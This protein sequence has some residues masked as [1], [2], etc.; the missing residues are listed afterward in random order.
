MDRRL[1]P[2]MLL[3]L[4]AMTA[5]PDVC[6][7]A[8]SSRMYHL[9][10]GAD[11]P[12]LTTYAAAIERSEFTLDKG[13]HFA[14]VESADGADFTNAQGGDLCLAFRRGGKTVY[15]MKD[16]AARP[17]IAVSYPDIMSYAF[18]PFSDISVSATFFV[19]SS[20]H[21]ILS[22][23]ITNRGD[24]AVLLEVRPFL[25]S[26]KRF[27]KEVEVRAD[28]RSITCT[29]QESPD[30][31][32]LDHG[33]PYVA[34]VRDL[35]VLSEVADRS[36]CSQ[37]SL[38][39]EDEFSSTFDRRLNPEDSVRNVAFSKIVDLKPREVHR[40]TVVRSVSRMDVDPALLVDTANRL[41]SLS[42]APFLAGNEKLFGAIPPLKETDPDLQ[43]IDAS[44]FALM[45][46]AMLPPEGRCRSN[47]YVFSREPQWGW[48][49]GGQ[50]FHES[51]TML[52]YALLEPVRAMNSQ[53][54]FIDR[55]KADGYINY[56][57]GPYLDEDIPNN[58][59]LTTSAP[60]Y[61]WQN[62]EVFNVTHD[63]KFLE[64]TYG[65]ASRFYRYYVENRD[66]DGDGLCEWGGNAVLESV[67]DGLVAV[68]DQ[69]G[70]PSEFE[71]VDLNCMLVVEARSLSTMARELGKAADADAWD[72]DA[73]RRTT[74]INRE[75]WDPGTGFYY[76][77]DKKHHSFSHQTKNDLKRQEIIG[78][79]PLWAGIARTDQAATLVAALTDTLKFWRKYGVPSLA[80]DDRYYNPRGYWNGPVWIPWNYLIVRGL[81]RYGYV[82]EA[83]E[84][85]DRIIAAVS[86]GLK[87]GHVF[88]E[89]YSPDEPWGGYHNTYLWDGLISRM[90]RD[91]ETAEIEGG[92]RH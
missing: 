85:T 59:E 3:L 22:I 16:M 24:A 17:V 91:V 76:H 10:A 69:V 45:R 13:Y 31:W 27:Y 36:A 73:M 50:V 67:R 80:A 14:F 49:H 44:A 33:I 18:L 61:A 68:W 86:A 35:F 51:L 38:P 82:A 56:R 65:S 89:F 1:A 21:A 55:Q 48:G 42:P 15:A 25:R 37:H 74:L 47:Y 58:G 63:R 28:R 41:A 66:K 77:V 92:L 83:R 43:M 32:V 90:V 72:A 70:D 26:A 87:R 84:L 40:L 5:A 54:V 11:S 30:R 29:H 23:E 19:Y 34:K 78:F 8:D 71:A 2:L 62:L 79:L 4:S 7:Q 64:E 57:T 12:V 9:A 52:A 81:L 88:W 6:A 39:Q 60:W 75:M 20:H 46:Q 53:R